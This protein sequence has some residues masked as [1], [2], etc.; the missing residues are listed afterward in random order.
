LLQKSE[1]KKIN[2]KLKDQGNTLVPLV[3]FISKKGFAKLEIAI[4][5]GKKYHDKRESLKDKDIKREI[6]RFS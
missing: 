2:N 4:G 1:L 6:D 5:K 3:L